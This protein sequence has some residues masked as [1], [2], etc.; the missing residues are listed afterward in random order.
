MRSPRNIA[1]PERFG[2]YVLAGLFAVWAV[3]SE[4]L[5]LIYALALV[6][7]VLWFWIKGK[8]YSD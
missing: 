6:V 8:K 5:L 4:I 7:L 1:V 3:R 2:V